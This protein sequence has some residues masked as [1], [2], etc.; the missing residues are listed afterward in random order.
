V[1]ITT[2]ELEY[3]GYAQDKKTSRIVVG[4]CFAG[5]YG[6]G[7]GVSV[8]AGSL[9]GV[10]VMVAPALVLLQMHLLAH[11]YQAL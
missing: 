8:S 3:K 6:D 7:D 11:S 2:R 1:D 5:R 9:A 10:V 4:C